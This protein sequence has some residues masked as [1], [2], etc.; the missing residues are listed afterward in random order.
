MCPPGGNNATVFVADYVD[1]YEFNA[2]EK[3]DGHY[4]VFSMTAACL[5]EY[6]A[7][8]NPQRILKVDVMLGEVG[9]ALALVPLEKHLQPHARQDKVKS[10]RVCTKCTYT[11]ESGLLRLFLTWLQKTCRAGAFFLS[12]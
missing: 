11:I 2:F 3:S 10:I 6:R 9:L 4:A 8:K 7:V 12:W 1:H 5:L